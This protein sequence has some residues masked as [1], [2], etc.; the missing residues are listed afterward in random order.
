MVQRYFHHFM[1]LL[2]KN[3]AAESMKDSV[4]DKKEDC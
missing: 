2:G 4:L 1:L 3:N